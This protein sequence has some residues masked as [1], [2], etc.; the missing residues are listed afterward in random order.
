M[1]D[2]RNIQE[3]IDDAVA[4]IPPR[5]VY[6]MALQNIDVEAMKAAKTI[7]REELCIKMAMGGFLAGVRF[8]LEN[9]DISDDGNG[10]ADYD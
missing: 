2:E 10:D 9:L 4:S 8:T 1:F 5:E 6:K 7:K 3:L